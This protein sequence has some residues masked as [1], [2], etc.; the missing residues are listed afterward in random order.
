MIR[1]PGNAVTGADIDRQDADVM[2]PSR[3][4]ES[5]P[6]DAE[7][8]RICASHTYAGIV[9]KLPTPKR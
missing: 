2:N 7:G 6:R 5:F 3:I 4:D 8:N 1:Q 9:E